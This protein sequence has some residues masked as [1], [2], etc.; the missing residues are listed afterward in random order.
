MS[1][2]TLFGEVASEKVV[3]VASVPFRSPFRY[4]G[5]K[6]WFVPRVRK[7]LK[8]KGT[9]PTHFIEPF[10]G[11]AI[12]SLTVAFEE[13][14]DHIVLVELDR[15]VAAV[16]KTI[17][18]GRGRWLAKRIL[19]FDLKPSTIKEVL[20]AEPEAMHNR[21]FAT[22][23]KNR[24]NRGG[25]LAA[26]AGK[27]K[28][29]ENGKGLRSRWYP[30]TLYQ[31][32]MD[33][34]VVK[35]RLSFFEVD[36]LK[37]MEEHADNENAVFFIDPPYTVAAKR[38]YTH[39]DIDHEKLFEIT[40]MLRGDFLMTYDHTDEVKDLARKHGLDARLVPM[41]N[42]HHAKKMELLISRDFTWLE[43]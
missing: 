6:T 30:E 23:V 11:G 41:K 3:N 43:S 18:N 16:W 14:A 22:V 2:K 31:R 42:T 21:A 33:I 34:T 1:Q 35:D 25:I 26:G 5:G 28:K 13:L 37:F 38:L 40:S 8:S 17:L 12:V 4:P 7:W 39:W 19:H 29:G 32:I 24:I 36:G 10:A 9:R 15:D 27:V 20:E